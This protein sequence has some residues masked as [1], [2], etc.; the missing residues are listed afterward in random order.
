MLLQRI[1]YKLYSK[2]NRRIRDFVIRVILKLEG[3]EYYSETLRKIFYDYHK[4]N[5]GMYSHGGCFVRG[6]IDKFTS[7]GRYCSIAKPLAIRNRN[8]PLELKS[9]HAFF[10]NPDL[11][12]CDADII[13][14]NPLAIGNDVWIGQYSVILPHVKRI[15]DGAVVGA[16]AVVNKDIPPYAVVLG[17]PARIVRYRF[18]KE[19]IEELLE[20]RWWERPIED[21]KSELNEFQTPYKEI[22]EKS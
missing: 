19:I 11:G 3:G 17:N 20:S 18:P 16:G 21:L 13:D 6:Y 7:I 12:I 4:V 15:G 9:M 8:H 2:D 5:V 14:Y 10:F 1:L 22:T